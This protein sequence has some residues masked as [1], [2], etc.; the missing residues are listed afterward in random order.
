MSKKDALDAL[1]SEHEA[2]SAKMNN[3]F[4]KNNCQDWCLASLPQEDSSEWKRL[5]AQAET[6]SAKI[7]MAILS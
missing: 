6:V 4:I 7:T 2:L 3:L 5:R 1:F